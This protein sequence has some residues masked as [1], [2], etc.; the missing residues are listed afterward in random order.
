MIK[1]AE[2]YDWMAR[3]IVFVSEGKAPPP[4]RRMLGPGFRESGREG[5]GRLFVR[6]YRQT[7]PGLGP[8]RLRELRR[9]PLD[10]RTNGV[11]LDG[12]GPG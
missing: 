4:P 8:L 9:A 7:Q 11:L 1:P 12:V 3:E 5:D 10:F 2:R 6:R